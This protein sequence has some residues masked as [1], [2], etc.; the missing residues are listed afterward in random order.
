[1]G[2]IMPAKVANVSQAVKFVLT[3]V[4]LRGVINRGMGSVPQV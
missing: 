4:Q 2:P 1:M 3:C